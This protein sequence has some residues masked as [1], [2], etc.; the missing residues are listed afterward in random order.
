M[1]FDLH[2]A[3]AAAAFMLATMGLHF[4]TTGIRMPSEAL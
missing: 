2:D 1:N 4:A 3:E